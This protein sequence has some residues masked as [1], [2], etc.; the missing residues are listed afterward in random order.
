[1]RLRTLYLAGFSKNVA[2]GLR[3]GMVVAPADKKQGIERAIRAT[4][5][6]TPALMTAIVCGWVLDGTVARLEQLKREDARY[7]QAV[8][9]FL[10]PLEWTRALAAEA[11]IAHPAGTAQ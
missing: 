6:N 1:M 9:Q 5:W 11:A 4:T 10:P 2:S 3:V 8:A 7:R